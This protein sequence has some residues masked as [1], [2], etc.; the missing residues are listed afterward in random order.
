[1]QLLGKPLLLLLIVSVGVS[2]SVMLPGLDD[3]PAISGSDA[4]SPV[5]VLL[6]K[7]HADEVSFLS[8][9]KDLPERHT[10][11]QVLIHY[12]DP[13]SSAYAA[14][15]DQNDLRIAAINLCNRL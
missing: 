6:R 2:A 9:R 15:I 14:M 3:A 7:D 1:M 13:G 10:Q 5:D 12:A 11:P 8:Q 4:V